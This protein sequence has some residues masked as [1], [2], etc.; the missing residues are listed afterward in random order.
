MGVDI[1]LK[2]IVKSMKSWYGIQIRGILGDEDRD[3]KELTFLNWSMS[4]KDA[5]LSMKYIANMRR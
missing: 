2:E 5:V 4:W 1:Q 3:D